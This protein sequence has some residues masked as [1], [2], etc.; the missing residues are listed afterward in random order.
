MADFSYNEASMHEWPESE[1]GCKYFTTT[2][3]MGGV[4]TQVLNYAIRMTREEFEI[5]NNP[6]SFNHLKETYSI[7]GIHA[8]NCFFQFANAE[9]AGEYA[10]FSFRAPN[11]WTPVSKLASPVSPELALNIFRELVNLIYEYSCCDFNKAQYH[12]LLCICKESV[13][14]NFNENNKIQ[15]RLLPMLY[16]VHTYYPG[17]PREVLCGNGNISSDLYMASYLY[18]SLRYPNNDSFYPKTLAF[19]QLFS[20]FYFSPLSF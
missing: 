8:P 13:F 7:L 4:S 6:R 11:G 15:I 5:T 16:D 20:L 2:V 19:L 1:I 14:V 17:L 3:S 9:A 12:P 10:L 18:L